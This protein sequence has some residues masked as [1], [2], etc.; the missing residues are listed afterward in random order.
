VNLLFINYNSDYVGY[1]I[2]DNIANGA[3][4]PVDITVI[5]AIA[6]P[7]FILSPIS[8]TIDM[9]MLSAQNLLFSDLYSTSDLAIIQTNIENFANGGGVFVLAG[10]DEIASPYD[11]FWINILGG[12]GSY[13]CSYAGYYPF[14]SFSFDSVCDPLLTGLTDLQ[15]DTLP[16]YIWYTELNDLDCLFYAGGS[17]VPCLTSTEYTGGIWTVRPMTNTGIIVFFSYSFPPY[18]KIGFDDGGAMQDAF[19]NLLFYAQFGGAGGDP[20]VIDFFGNHFD[21]PG[22]NDKPSLYRLFKDEK[23]TTNINI[24]KTF[25][26][27]ISIQFTEFEEE[28]NFLSTFCDNLEPCFYLNDI[29]LEVPVSYMNGMITTS[30]DVEPVLNKEV[31]KDTSKHIS[32]VVSIDHFAII[33]GGNYSPMTD[34]GFFNIDIRHQSYDLIRRSEHEPTILQTPKKLSRSD[35][36]FDDM[37]ITSLWD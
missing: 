24:E 9:I 22:S 6:N 31:F 11:E 33:T 19:N 12:T 28:Y 37:K 8:G 32:V 14:N 34:V 29:K 4:V 35:D 18:G 16:Q 5:D 13:D 21:I 1:D 36:R 17:A 2:Y 15:G 25:I 23:R 7:N 26:H 10:F 3:T 30:Y 27:D 20:H